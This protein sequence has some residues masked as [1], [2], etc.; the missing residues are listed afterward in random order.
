MIIFY[1]NICIIEIFCALK[2]ISLDGLKNAKYLTRLIT[3]PRATI[4]AFSPMFYRPYLRT[5][6]VFQRFV[7]NE[8][9]EFTD[10]EEN[11]AGVCHHTITADKDDKDPSKIVTE[12]NTVISRYTESLFFLTQ[13]SRILRR[14]D[15]NPNNYLPLKKH[16]FSDFG[17][18]LDLIKKQWL[19]PDGGHTCMAITDQNGVILEDSQISLRPD[20]KLILNGKTAL[21]PHLYKRNF[22][23]SVREARLTMIQEEINTLAANMLKDKSISAEISIVPLVQ[24]RMKISDVMNNIKLAQTAT[25]LYNLCTSVVKVNDIAEINDIII[26]KYV[27]ELKTRASAI[28]E[29]QEIITMDTEVVLAAFECTHAIIKACFGNANLM[30]ADLGPDQ[31]TQTAVVYCIMGLIG[32]EKFMEFAKKINF[33]DMT[34]QQTSNRKR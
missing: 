14:S 4:N 13:K 26:R 8:K 24:S 2:I 11:I 6:P 16:E 10:S 9:F 32:S 22:I 17:L 19:R 25:K 7:H 30:D 5:S 29:L 20:K 12:I 1:A 28:P 18:M 3:L 23:A 33:H 34:S 27:D 31:A 21:Q 15:E